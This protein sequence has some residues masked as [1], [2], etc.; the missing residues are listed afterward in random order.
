MYCRRALTALWISFFS[1]YNIHLSSCK[2][3]H[4]SCF[5]NCYGR[6]GLDQ[7]EEISVSRAL[8]KPQADVIRSFVLREE[9]IFCVVFYLFFLSFSLTKAV[10]VWQ[11]FCFEMT[12]RILV[13]WWLENVFQRFF[14]R[15]V[16][17]NKGLCS[18]TIAAATAAVYSWFSPLR[19]G[20]QAVLD[21]IICSPI[22]EN[23]AVHWRL[24][25]KFTRMYESVLL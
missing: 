11:T 20:F 23:I 15:F 19:L 14:L 21:C 17:G 12:L 18:L 24:V 10:N 8:S 22:N 4:G 5:D 3:W 7:P 16:K 13:S 25:N 2:S 9:M 6:T 1:H